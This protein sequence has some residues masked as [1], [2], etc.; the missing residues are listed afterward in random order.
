MGF[1][2]VEVM[3]SLALG[4]ILIVSLIEIFLS[5]NQVY[6]V[7]QAQARLQ[8]NG[9]F[10]LQ[11]LSN[12]IRTVGYKSC[13]TQ[14]KSDSFS[15]IIDFKLN[16][17]LYNFETEVQGSESIGKNTWSPPINSGNDSAVISSPVSGSDVLTLR[18]ITGPVVPLVSHANKTSPLIIDRGYQFA[19]GESVMVAN[20]QTMTIFK[21]TNSKTE[22]NGRLTFAAETSFNISEALAENYENGE[23]MAL[24][25]TTYYIRNNAQGIPSLYQKVFS[26]PV[27]EVV[28]GVEQMQ[29]IYGVDTTGDNAVDVYQSADSITDWA[30]VKSIQ[31]SL[32]LRTI[33]DNLTVGGPQ[34]YRLNSQLIRPEDSFL[35]AVFTQTISLRN[36]VK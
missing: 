15:Q 27:K 19:R 35:R 1:S 18:M 31:L 2:L 21:N 3:I 14:H 30:W 5:S 16:P 9:R 29:L 23:V 8:E 24:E 13:A 4:L 34:S 26:S 11:Y 36:R 20:C 32:V 28:E 17:Y 6:R 7:H 22:L 12:K 25:T 33:E 10:A